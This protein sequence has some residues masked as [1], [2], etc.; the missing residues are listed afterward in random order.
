MKP[1]LYIVPALVVGVLAGAAG[2]NRAWSRVA[3]MQ[4]VTLT[5]PKWILDRR[6][7]ALP[8]TAGMICGSIMMLPNS[9]NAGVRELHL[10]NSF[11]VVIT[12]P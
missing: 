11:R 3:T 5:C 12:K 1:I 6:P 8:L 2:E 4:N 7:G 9:P 10:E